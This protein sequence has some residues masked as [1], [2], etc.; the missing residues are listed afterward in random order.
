MRCH[1]SLKRTSAFRI[2]VSA[3][4]ITFVVRLRTFKI[5]IKMPIPI[6][7]RNGKGRTRKVKEKVTA[8][9]AID[10]RKELVKEGLV[11]LAIQTCII[12]PGTPRVKPRRNMSA[13]VGKLMK[14]T[15]GGR[16]A[17]KSATGQL[18]NTMRRCNEL[19]KKKPMRRPEWRTRH[20]HHRR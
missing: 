6:C 16:N 7:V 3:Q 2:D 20:R 5:Q 12:D 10:R 14:S 17:R 9:H 4:L 15:N 18:K 1:C 19:P 11:R 8:I 13:Y